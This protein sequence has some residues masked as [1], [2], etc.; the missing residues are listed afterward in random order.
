MR[1]A[2]PLHPPEAVR[3]V[4]ARVA[5]TIDDDRNQK[6][7]ALGHVTSAFDRQ[8]PL[9]A[10]VALVTGVRVGRNDRHEEGTVVDLLADLV[11]P[12]VTAAQLTLVKPD[13]DSGGTQGV[14]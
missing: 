2:R 3:H 12:G 7:Y 4:R 5:C 9:A 14:A 11:V 10:E 8:P 13:L 1:Q 6:D